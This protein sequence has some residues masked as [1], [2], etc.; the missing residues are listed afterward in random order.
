MKGLAGKVYNI[1]NMSTFNFRYAQTQDQN[2]A[3]PIAFT[4]PANQVAQSPTAPA[5]QNS[6]GPNSFQAVAQNPMFQGMTSP[7][8]TAFNYAQNQM[9]PKAKEQYAGMYGNLKQQITTGLNNFP[10]S[11]AYNPNLYNFTVQFVNFLVKNFDSVIIWMLEKGLTINMWI[12]NPYLAVAIKAAEMNPERLQIVKNIGTKIIERLQG[13]KGIK[14]IVGFV[15]AGKTTKYEALI[16]TLGSDADNLFEYDIKSPIDPSKIKQFLKDPKSF[17]PGE[18]KQIIEFIEKKAPEAYKSLSKTLNFEEILLTG[19]RLGE[20]ASIYKQ[21]AVKTFSGMSKALPA[22]AEVL[23]KI[24]PFLDVA[25]SSADFIDWL[26]VINNTGWDKMSRVDQVKFALSSLK[27]LATICYF[28]PPLIPMAPF[29]NM[30][31]SILQSIGIE[32]VESLGYLV[33]GTGFGGAEK[34]KAIQN[35]ASQAVGMPP[36]DPLALEIYNIIF[37]RFKTK[38]TNAL[39]NENNKST[40]EQIVKTITG[41]NVKT[42]FDEQIK[43]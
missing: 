11:V 33:E 8:G 19:A 34:A 4:P 7:S 29:I 24:A 43:H 40:S 18:Q 14:N 35:I 38:V 15:E 5:A 23:N 10:S 31:I 39:S 41:G 37:T 21:A 27:A 36:K 1:I 13:V 20:N 16:K 22:I 30:A 42:Y 32:G 12:K 28:I 25:I 2:V 6:K 26:R 3:A 9:D 17:S